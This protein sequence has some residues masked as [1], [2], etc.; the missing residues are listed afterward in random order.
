MNR[1][2]GEPH[3]HWETGFWPHHP[4][5]RVFL[6]IIKGRVALFSLS[7]LPISK[8]IFEA[9]RLNLCQWVLGACSSASRAASTSVFGSPQSE[10]PGASDHH[11]ILL[12][13]LQDASEPLMCTKSAY[14]SALTDATQTVK[15]DCD[16]KRLFTDQF[17]HWGPLCAVLLTSPTDTRLCLPPPG[18][19]SQPQGLWDS[20]SIPVLGPSGTWQALRADNVTLSALTLT[21]RTLVEV[22]ARRMT[23]L[24]TPRSETLTDKGCF[25]GRPGL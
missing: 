25:L 4:T 11:K 21:L 2:D 19:W 16:P 3:L 12:L 14:S 8:D 18:R 6:F 9:A 13:T 22:K 10:R 23:L 17:L 15:F 5:K 20:L 24:I 7:L 1:S